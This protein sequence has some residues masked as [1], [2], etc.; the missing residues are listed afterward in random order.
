V[1]RRVC[2]AASL[3]EGRNIL[4]VAP[5]TL[6]LRI[7]KSHGVAVGGVIAV[8]WETGHF[9]GAFAPS[10]AAVSGLLFEF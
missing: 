5:A 2:S 6:W 10:P 9:V 3:A 7:E 4:Q 1:P 8:N